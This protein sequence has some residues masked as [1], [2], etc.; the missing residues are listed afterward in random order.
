[1]SG[2][3]RGLERI[4]A[5]RV[6]DVAPHLGLKMV[7]G[8]SLSPCPAC[9]DEVRGRSRPDHRGPVGT[10]RDGLGWRCHRCGSGGGTVDL[11]ACR[12]FG[13]PIGRG[14]PRW[15]E[16]FEWA[17]SRGLCES[18]SSTRH[19][20]PKL[21]PIPE[22]KLQDLGTK[23]P[24]R[25]EVDAVWSGASPL[26]AVREV[27]SYVD[28]RGLDP[29]AVEWLDLARALPRDARLPDWARFGGTSWAEGGW[30]L[31]VPMCGAEGVLESVHARAV[32]ARA[33]QDGDARPKGVS[34]RGFEIRGLVFADSFARRLLELG[35]LPEWWG[36]ATPLCVVVAEGLPD[37]LKVAVSVHEEHL[38]GP[39]TI[40]VISGSWGTALAARIPDGA[41]VFAA[42]HD[43][44]TGDKYAGQ[45]A[46]T[47]GERCTVMR[48][49]PSGLEND[50]GRD[51]Q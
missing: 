26:S 3:G 35:E 47:L 40:G 9:G 12:L 2:A 17:A 19:P 37:F 25:D 7:R 15:G 18:R 6:Q 38:R 13:E 30:Q 41:R 44:G 36:S 1:M 34:P 46:D 33:G 29:S 5:F 32:R 43:D 42:M 45:V 4:A 10:T 49:R 24:P 14:D 22:V 27:W 50:N 16:L 28:G 8:R 31:L 11:I 21:R 20:A 51:G 48:V 39:A 23:R